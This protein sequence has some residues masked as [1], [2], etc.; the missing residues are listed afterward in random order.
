MNTP[1]TST[2][3]ATAVALFVLLTACTFEPPS[4]ERAVRID[5]PIEHYRITRDGLDLVAWREELRLFRDQLRLRYPFEDVQPKL[6][7][8]PR[9]VEFLDRAVDPSMIIWRDPASFWRDPATLSWFE[10]INEKGEIV[11]VFVTTSNQSRE[12]D[13]R[14]ISWCLEEK[15][16]SPAVVDGQPVA[17]LRTASINL[18]ESRLHIG[19][20]QKKLSTDFVIVVVLLT[21]ILGVRFAALRV[22]R[23]RTRPDDS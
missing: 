15:V 7:T 23:W 5:Y 12:D 11:Q 19:F 10:L 3:A 20:W 21:I 16:W 1:V 14:I 9:E 18:G 22:R 6:G 8:D 2:R 13:A 17:S 4:T